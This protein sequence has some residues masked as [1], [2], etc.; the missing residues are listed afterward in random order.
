L[1]GRS[2]PRHNITIAGFHGTG[3]SSTAQVVARRMRR[4]LFDF[5]EE[6]QKRN[7]LNLYSIARMGRKPDPLDVET[8]LIDDLSYRREIV[9]A[10]DCEGESYLEAFDAL[11]EISYVVMLDPPFE[12]IWQRMSADPAY[13]GELSRLG[14]SGVYGKWQDS[15]VRRDSADL[16]LT[17]PS[18]S[19]LDNARLILHCFFT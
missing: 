18:L 3:K 17:D 2:N 14:R 7:R 11:R 6:I 10:L 5:S 1:S 9:V 4:Q 19:I 16:I 8:K 12:N 15:V 13:A